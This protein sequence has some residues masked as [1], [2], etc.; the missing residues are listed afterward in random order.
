MGAGSLDWDG[1]LFSFQFCRGLSDHVVFRVGK[2]TEEE[3]VVEVMVGTQ[4]FV[5][6]GENTPEAEV[7]ETVECLEQSGEGKVV[8]SVVDVGIRYK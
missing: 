6:S 7:S 2:E 3:F 4:C 5:T 8:T 1:L